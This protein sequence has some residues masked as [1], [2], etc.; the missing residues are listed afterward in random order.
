MDM[1]KIKLI[2]TVY[3]LISGF[4]LMPLVSGR[5]DHDKLSNCINTFSSSFRGFDAKQDIISTMKMFCR[6]DPQSAFICILQE[7][8]NC[9]DGTSYSSLTSLLRMVNAETLQENCNL[10]SNIQGD[11]LNCLKNALSLTNTQLRQCMISTSANV[12]N[13]LTQTGLQVLNL[14]S[15]IG[16]GQKCQDHS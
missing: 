9:F 1:M 10:L 6:S 7:S 8:A 5:C 12:F 3:V 14:C 2:L 4:A 13:S 16:S 15:L 11:S